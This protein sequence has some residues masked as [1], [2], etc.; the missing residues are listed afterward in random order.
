[1]R[2]RSAAPAP[3]PP[4][5]RRAAC[6]APLTH[7]RRLVGARFSNAIDIRFGNKIDSKPLCNTCSLGCPVGCRGGRR[8]AA[9]P[10]GGAAAGGSAAGQHRLGP[11]RG[12]GQG[13]GIAS[14]AGA[15]GGRRGCTAALQNAK[16][17]S[18]RHKQRVS[19]VTRSG[20]LPRAPTP[21]AAAVLVHCRLPVGDNPDALC[22]AADPMLRPH[23]LPALPASP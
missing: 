14:A 21:K 15:D 3:T 16:G 8:R 10:A 6:T 20:P 1:M 13:F 9:A 12:A 11:L 23:L 4:A 17:Q 19:E 18:A 22:R 7:V 2:G 5:T